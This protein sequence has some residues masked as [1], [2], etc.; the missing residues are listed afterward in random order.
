MN[1][2]ATIHTLEIEPILN[3][4]HAEHPGKWIREAYEKNHPCVNNLW[5]NRHDR[6][7]RITVN[8]HR[9]H[10]APD[11]KY[12]FTYGGLQE[13]Q[14]EMQ[15]IC[16]ELEIDS[17]IIRRLDVCLDVDVPY[18]QTQKITRL[19][20][21]M[22][23]D[24]IGMDN[25]YASIDP[26]TLEPKTFRLDNGSRDI[27]G[28]TIHPTQQIEH[29][30]RELIDQISYAGKPIINRFELRVMGAAA[31][32]GKTEGDIA[33][34]WLERL[35]GLREHG[36]LKLCQSINERLVEACGRYTELVGNAGS[37]E[38]NNFIKAHADH[39]YT[40]QQLVD[41]LGMLGMNDPKHHAAN[42]ITRSG[43]L[44]RLYR[45]KQIQAE[46]DSMKAALVGFLWVDKKAQ[47]R[48]K[49]AN[50]KTA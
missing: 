38:I 40:R 20:A 31:G 29:Y 30:N 46:I 33:A 21:L 18:E 22:L 6:T 27:N 49:T 8:P 42:L 48:A 13:H 28:K 16:H 5:L 17:Y 12:I 45:W 11:G 35:D 19:I 43:N 24:N 14:Q 2:K 37:T 41:L 10:T 9:L 39:I 15:T 23:G 3:S 34:S 26:V 47:K 25:R 7:P 32:K 1:Y 44:F 4:D 50:T 36:A